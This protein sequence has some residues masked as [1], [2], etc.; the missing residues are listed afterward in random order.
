MVLAVVL[1]LRMVP[2]S[3]ALGQ[4]RTASRPESAAGR[5]PT[6]PDSQT[7]RD[8]IVHDSVSI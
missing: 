5:R 6:Q 8:R 4:R 3:G 1:V 7:V 2:D